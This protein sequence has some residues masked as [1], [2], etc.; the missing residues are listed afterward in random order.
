LSVRQRAGTLSE[1]GEV[2]DCLFDEFEFHLVGAYHSDGQTYGPTPGPADAPNM[3]CYFV[4][5]FGFVFRSPPPP[6]PG[7]CGPDSASQCRGRVEGH[8]CGTPSRPGTCV[9]APACRC[10]S[11]PP[12]PPPATCG[13]GSAGYCVGLPQG[14]H[15]RAGVYSGRCVGAPNCYC[16][17]IC[18]PGGCR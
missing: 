17:L 16:Q 6:P 10:E 13:P 5:H 15:C 9:G 8:V 7:T 14:A 3:F 18:P 1:F 2:T 4:E 11:G 12:P